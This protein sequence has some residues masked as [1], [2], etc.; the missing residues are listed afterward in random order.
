MEPEFDEIKTF[1]YHGKANREI[2]RNVDEPFLRDLQRRGARLNKWC[3]LISAEST[4]RGVEVRIQ[5][6]AGPEVQP[7]VW[8]VL[9]STKPSKH[10]QYTGYA[11]VYFDEVTE[12]F[13]GQRTELIAVPS[14]L[15]EEIRLRAYALYEQRG[16]RSGFALNDW[17]EAEAEILGNYRRE[18]VK[19]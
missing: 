17:L 7:L 9:I 4:D 5:F 11:F 2:V 1:I 6:F 16:R 18:S 12:E 19:S 10:L 15:E 3:H 13:Q 14:S 8:S